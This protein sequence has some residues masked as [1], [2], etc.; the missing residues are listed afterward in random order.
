MNCEE[1]VDECFEDKTGHLFKMLILAT[2]VLN[3]IVFQD[4]FAK[5]IK[6]WKKRNSVKPNTIVLS[7]PKETLPKCIPVDLAEFESHIR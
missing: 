3:F 7:M 6:K 2:F 5:F 1:D 4:Y